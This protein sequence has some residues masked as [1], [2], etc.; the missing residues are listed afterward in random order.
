[1]R[2]S[3][4]AKAATVL[5]AATV[6]ALPVPVAAAQTGSA[7]LPIPLG[8]LGSLGGA[9]QP[10]TP[11]WRESGGFPYTATAMWG[12]V[13]GQFK[14]YVN[15]HFD[16]AYR[17]NPDSPENYHDL[18][19]GKFRFVNETTGASR[20]GGQFPFYQYSSWAIAHVYG[21]S[22]SLFT[23]GETNPFRVEVFN[24]EGEVTVLGRSELDL[25]AECPIPRD[26]RP[27]SELL[28]ESVQLA[29]QGAKLVIR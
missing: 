3:K 17:G 11:S 7:G 16:H 4:F 24:D 27:V 21:E 8:S 5:T 19:E 20:T 22:P 6:L 9:P 26:G 15:I 13:S 12:S 1:M 23:P 14:C 29:E 2:P 10:T 28:G 25:P 18:P